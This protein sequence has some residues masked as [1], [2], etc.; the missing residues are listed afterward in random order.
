MRKLLPFLT[1][2]SLGANG[3]QFFH[4]SELSDQLDEKQRT[5][6]TLTQTLTLLKQDR[7]QSER[8]LASL[9]DE[10][11]RLVRTAGESATLRTDPAKAP[12]GLLS[13]TPAQ[14]S[15]SDPFL[16]SVMSLAE[17]AGDLNQLFQKRPEKEIPEMR[18]VKEADWLR[19]AQNFPTLDSDEN[20]QKAMRE[21]RTAAKQE[22]G[23]VADSAA[24]AFIKANG[25][26]P[27]T[28]ISQLKPYFGDAIT[29]DMLQRYQL[30]SSDSA[31]IP[32][33][34]DPN[35]NKPDFILTEKSPIDP[36]QDSRFTLFINSKGNG[37]GEPTSGRIVSGW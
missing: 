21:I 4:S 22:F 34:K 37:N 23:L 3:Y 31:L 1:L 19:I 8:Q 5:E 36:N 9:S 13:Q 25:G 10:N 15:E 20:I 14:T 7:T 2:L 28:D 24:T 30:V 16:K 11:S 17:R 29:D 18:L 27:P 26:Q 32:F 12:A 33:F 6:S 35:S